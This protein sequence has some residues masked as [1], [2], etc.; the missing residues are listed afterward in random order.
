MAQWFRKI[1][2]G[3]VKDEI[4]NF[5]GEEGNIFFNVNTGEFRLSDGVTPGGLPIGGGGGGGG[6]A[7]IT[8]EQN[9][10]PKGSVTRLNFTN[11]TVTV[12]GTTANITAPS[13]GGGGGGG[14]GSL[15]EVSTI[16]KNNNWLNRVFLPDAIRFDDALFTVTNIGN[17]D[18]KIGL[19]SGGYRF[20]VPQ[21]H[22]FTRVGDELIYTVIDSGEVSLT[23]SNGNELYDAYDIGTNQYEYDIN[24]N[25]DLIL[26]FLTV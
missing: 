6:P 22:G 20:P 16:D 10:T 8:V 7:L 21:F 18:V 12:S 26:R 25:G 11:S 15:N 2:A 19:N 14:G 4:S 1:K 5:V 24:A 3:L 13:G 17:S 23:D 9:G